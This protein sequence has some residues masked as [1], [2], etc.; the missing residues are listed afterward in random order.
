[1]SE[2]ESIVMPASAQLYTGLTCALLVLIP[3]LFTV[4]WREK[5]GEAARWK[6]LLIGAA[7]FLISARVLE[8]GV[9]AL[10]LM[11][12]SPV[13]RFI[14][15]NPVAYILYGASM[16]GLFEEAGR[17]VILKHFVKKANTRENAVMYGIGHG[18]AEVLAVTLPQALLFFSIVRAFSNGNIG[19]AMETLG[20]NAETA[21]AALP[22]VQAAAGFD[23]GAM[24]ITVLER[25]MCMW[26][27]IMLTVI[28]YYGVQARQKRWTVIAVLLHMAADLVPAA[29]Q[30]M[31]IPPAFTEMWVLMVT[32]VI[33]VI[34][35]PL[36]KKLR[37]HTRDTRLK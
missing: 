17:H 9:H 36:Y 24:L 31:E 34:A 5:C 7:G 33:C 27:H 29:S 35:V 4:I 2:F 8:M 19:Q 37:S 28:V 30:I 25:F 11:V 15:G 22:A 26:L 14:T 13:S 6:A 18:A 16:A 23:A 12:D 1:M 20:I 3:F 10:C 32:L 21:A